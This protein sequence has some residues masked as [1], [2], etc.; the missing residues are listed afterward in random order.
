[1]CGEL[2]IRTAMTDS[3]RMLSRAA[4]RSGR[5]REARWNLRR[6]R[7]LRLKMKEWRKKEPTTG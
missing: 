2:P 5:E 6:L 3:M 4:L 7:W 1:M